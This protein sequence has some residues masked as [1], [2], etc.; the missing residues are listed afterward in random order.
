[1][2]GA[3]SVFVS[4]L[5]EVTTVAK[6]QLG[7]LRWVGNKV[8][9]YVQYYEAVA[10]VDG[11]AGEVCY[12]YTLDGYKNHY[13]T[14]DLD[15]SLE[16]GAGVLQAIMSDEEYG[17]IQI[18]GDATL[19]IGLHTDAVDGGNLTP[20]GAA[21]GS[22]DIPTAVTDHICA[23]VGDESDKEIVCDFPF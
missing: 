18:K 23:I 5:T 16:V 15:Q 10:A 2:P 1:M 4:A 22:L 21:D 17:W 12:Y 7:D 19:S 14:S 9:K 13:V 8:Y 11:V 20:T 6:D 3:K